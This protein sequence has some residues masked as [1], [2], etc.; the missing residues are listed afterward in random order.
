MIEK[1]IKKVFEP[2]TCC[3]SGS[4]LRQL[5]VGRTSSAE[6][7]WPQEERYQD[8]EGDE[9]NRD[10]DQGPVDGPLLGQSVLPEILPAMPV[11]LRPVT[12]DES[13]PCPLLL[14]GEKVRTLEPS[15]EVPDDRIA[16]NPP[17]AL[18]PFDEPQPA[19]DDPEDEE[20]QDLQQ[21]QA[22]QQIELQPLVEPVLGVR[23][24]V[25]PRHAP[26]GLDLTDL[27]I[28]APVEAPG[29]D[30]GQHDCRPVSDRHMNS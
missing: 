20:K 6:G 1:S 12:A 9:K 7:A 27:E 11:E 4:M 18:E 15:P 10:D 8:E 28:D 23:E 5:L 16:V 26:P 21:G 19:P 25:V 24:P 29:H 22:P 13:A 14:N 2:D 17:L 3:A 30:D